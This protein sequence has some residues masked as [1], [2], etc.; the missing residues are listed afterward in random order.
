MKALSP[1]GSQTWG[2]MSRPCGTVRKGCGGDGEPG[3]RQHPGRAQQVWAVSPQQGFPCS[4]S[5]RVT[6]Q[7]YEA[8]SP[9]GN[10]FS[11]WS[12]TKFSFHVEAGRLVAVPGKG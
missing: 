6:C 2:Q 11:R 3:Q 8:G 9:A 10:R 12:G 4:S 7:S 1:R 5:P